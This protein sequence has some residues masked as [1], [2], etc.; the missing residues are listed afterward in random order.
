[1]VSYV[2]QSLPLSQN[3]WLSHIWWVWEGNPPILYLRRLWHSLKWSQ[4]FSHWDSFFLPES[5]MSEHLGLTDTGTASCA[6][7][8]N[9]CVS[10]CQQGMS[11]THIMPSSCYKSIFFVPCYE[12]SINDAYPF[13]GSHIAGE[14]MSLA[15][16]VLVSE[17]RDVMGFAVSDIEVP[18]VC[19]RGIWCRV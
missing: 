2:N 15:V 9:C 4:F 13:Q 18:E 12:V 5:G 14:S 11:H 17:L 1:M 10:L 7:V 6:S 19:L 3:P 8:L 16:C